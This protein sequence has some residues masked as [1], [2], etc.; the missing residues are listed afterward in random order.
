MFPLRDENPTETFPWVTI[1]LIAANVLVFLYQLSLGVEGGSPEK[2]VYTY[3]LIPYEVTKGTNITA[4]V[5]PYI[6]LP[7]FT[8]MFLHGGFLHIISNMWY[9]WIFGNN[10]EDT[11]GHFKFIFFY[12]LAGLGGT[13]GHIL[14]NPL[15]QT[16][17]LGASGAIAGV[18]GAYLLLFPRARIITLLIIVFF[19]EI[20]SLPALFLIGFWFVLQL[21]SGVGSIAGGQSGGVAWFAHVGG[22]IAGFI[23][24]LILPK[25]KKARPQKEYWV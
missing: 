3:A 23:L 19:I 14:S 8:S 16:P 10:V 7:I 9:L 24:I 18:L 4:E 12:L 25:R 1:A 6:Y 22:F 17:S 13:V 21:L 20:I 2:F 15:S 11:L 5:T